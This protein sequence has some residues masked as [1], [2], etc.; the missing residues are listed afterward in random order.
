MFRDVMQYQQDYDGYVVYNWWEWHVD[1][2]P[3]IK[4]GQVF[5]CPSSS[6]G[7]PRPVAFA[8]YGFSDGSRRTGTFYCNAPQYG[9]SW[10]E[11]YG[12]YGKNE[13]LLGNFGGGY[14]SGLANDS[15]VQDPASVIMIGEVMGF[16]ED[17]DGDWRVGTFQNR[18]YFEQG[19]T[20]WNE[21]W[22]QIAGRHNGGSNALFM[23]GHAKWFSTQWHRSTDGRHA[24][25]PARENYAATA[26]W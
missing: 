3:Y 22:N 7:Q 13:E 17:T 25:C 12:H 20:T 21:L 24:W 2:D 16:G 6:H 10:P 19:G 9:S 18:P 15:S 1:L 26:A 11:I 23:D 14:G 8:N 5:G 4:N